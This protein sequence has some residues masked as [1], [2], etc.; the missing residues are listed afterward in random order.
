M[1]FLSLKQAY[2][3]IFILG[4]YYLYLVNSSVTQFKLEK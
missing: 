4:I 1:L 2:W 3:H